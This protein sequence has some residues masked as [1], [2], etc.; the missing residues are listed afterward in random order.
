MNDKTPQEILTQ[1]LRDRADYLDGLA[2]ILDGW[3]RESLDGGWST[4]QVDPNIASAN[5]CRRE[6]SR[7]RN[8]IAKAERSK[9]AST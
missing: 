7:A 6:A 1:A 2:N 5:D 8:A 4:H 9:A 3:A